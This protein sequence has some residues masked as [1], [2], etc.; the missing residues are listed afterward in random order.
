MYVGLENADALIAIDT[1]SNRVITTVPIGQ[2]PQAL[3]YVSDAVP[4]GPG[5]VG[6][7][8]LGVAAQ[9]AHVTLSPTTHKSGDSAYEG[10][11]RYSSGV[12]QPRQAERVLP[13]RLIRL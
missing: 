12:E 4:H 9:A 10:T 13:C 2:A 6:L 11:G 1:G 7:E 5:T 3:V 8:A